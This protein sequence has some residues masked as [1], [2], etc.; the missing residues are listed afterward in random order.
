VSIELQFLQFADLRPEALLLVSP[1]GTVLAAGRAAERLG[2]TPT[3]LRGKLLADLIADDADALAA[4]L[5]SCSRTREQVLGSLTIRTPD[6]RLLPCRA[7]GAVFRPYSAQDDS[8][9]LL[10]LVPR[11]EEANHSLAPERQSDTQRAERE[12]LLARLEAERA[13]LQVEI[14]ERRRQGEALRFL[15]EAGDLLAS[16]L[17]YE[18]TLASVARLVVPHLADWCSVYVVTE[19]S[20][21]RQLAV[22]HVD[23][24]RVE[25]ARQLASRYPPDPNAPRGVPAVLRSGRAELVEEITEEMILA[26]A[27]DAE[28]LEIIRSLGLRSVMTVPLNARGRTLGAILFVAAESGRRYGADDLALAE[29]LARRAALAVDNAR[30]YREAQEAVRRHEEIAHRL[31]LLIE[32]SGSLTRSP[33]LSAV[34]G[35]ILDLS[36]RLIAADAHAIWRRA[37]ESGSWELVRSAGLSPDYLREAG[38]IAPSGPSMPDRPIVA[39]DVQAAQMLHDR[40]SAYRTE[41]I[42]SLLVVPLQ[43]HGEVAGTLTFYYRSR[44]HFEEVTIGLA[45]AL[46]NLAGSAIGMAELYERQSVLRQRAEEADHR[47]DEFLAMLAHELRNPL[48]PVRNALQ[49]LNLAGDNLAASTQARA[50]IERQVRHLARLVDDLLDV[51]RIS[52]GKVRLRLER[53]D[54]SALVRSAVEDRRSHLKEGG[55]ELALELAAGPLW[56]DADPTRI[57]QVVDNLLVNANKFTDP[58]GQVIVRVGP[59]EAGWVGVSVV[60]SGIGITADMLPL[61]WDPFAQAD[62]SLD[63]SRGGLGLGLALV[64]GLVELHGGRVRATSAGPGQGADFSVL[65]PLREAPSGAV[66]EETRSGAPAA[67]SLRVLVIEDHRDAAESLRMLLELSGERVEVTHEGSAGLEAARRSVPDV[68]LCDIG[69]PGMSGYEV[70]RALRDCVETAGVYLVAVSGYGQPED[71]EK[72]LRAGFDAHL[73]KP[74]EP[75]EL[76]RLLAARKGPRR[77]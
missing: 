49:V 25:W 31:A 71:R 55:L 42:I 54:L 38:R 61:L 27:R 40:L 18:K 24:A 7:E 41:G 30:L 34:L 66:R 1:D 19:G 52:R 26:G 15:A 33:E 8:L 3:E 29:E 72:S 10:A 70:A 50:I 74:V 43:V 77:S 47:K 36:G 73:V 46:A 6:G 9:V 20:Q 16:S 56:V 39:E 53:L 4:Y 5:Q 22:A 51:S 75:D 12:A 11:P 69:L 68:V 62:T 60:D 17:D 44:Q 59:R 32:A 23:P 67:V 2:L 21:F 45:T 48:G 65:L 76:R 35:A 64:K 58:G 63:R 13:L 28:H 14:A 37:P 57:A